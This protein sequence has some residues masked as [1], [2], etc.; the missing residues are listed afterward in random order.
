M[1][2]RNVLLGC[3]LLGILLVGCAE[4]GQVPSGW[5]PACTI[6]FKDAD[7]LPKA[8]E[9]IM[10]QAKV[11]DGQLILTAEEQT[12]GQIVLKTPRFPGSVRLEVIA[13]L[14]GPNTCDLSPFL[15]GDENGYHTAYLLQFGA[16]ENNENRIRRA[17]EIV[18]AKANNKVLITP[19]KKHR[20]VAENNGGKLRL[21][22]DGTEILS[23]TDNQPLKGE[24][25]D[26]IGFYTWGSMLVIEKITIYTRSDADE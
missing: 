23:Y 13:C 21:I 1:L 16:A 5:K 3:S 8:W 19:G 6:D 24:G 11:A 17:G 4:H 15:N 25:H 26:M 22:V 18:D 10:G 20:V 12:D 7:K 9:A 14:K 2:V